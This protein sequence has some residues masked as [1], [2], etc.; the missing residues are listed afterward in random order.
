MPARSGTDVL[1]FVEDP[2]AANYI[3]E[4]PSVLAQRGLRARLLAAGSAADYLRQR[5]ISAEAVP[6]SATAEEVLASA[7]PRLLMV[8]TSENPDTLGLA[9][10]A[11]ARLA[12][13]ESVG[14]VD[15][16]ANAEYR[17]QG[18]TDDPLAYA[19]NWLLL[20]DRR[21]REA[22][23]ALGYPAER[24]VVCG[25]PHY[26]YVRETA[27]RLAREGRSRLRAREL[28]EAPADRKVVV[29]VAE[30][31]TGLNPRQFQRSAEYTLAG[32]GT[33]TGRTEIVLEE[34]LDAVQLVKPRPYLVLRL[35]P[36]N[37]PDEFTTY[38]NEFDLVSSGGSPLELIYVADLVVGMTSMV[39]LEA[40]LLGRP[41]LSI[42]PRAVERAWLPS[43]HMGLTACATTRSQLRSTIVDLLQ[44]NPQKPQVDADSGIVFGSLRRTADF[45]EWRLSG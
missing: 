1:I 25:H 3:A 2:G 10:V 5:G 40:A 13:I 18:R 14:V 26:D 8:G 43:I 45:I 23:V 37:T 33:S 11:E 24:A 39:L 44:T 22:Y 36:K 7:A 42:I 31:S 15:A 4:L 32:R 41:T 35:H 30:V 16:L 28:P 9:L 17:F 21:T 20:P 38:L 6:F 34:F 12:G 19:P 29:F 27:A